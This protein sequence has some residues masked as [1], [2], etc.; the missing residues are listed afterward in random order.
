[1]LARLLP[2]ALV[3]F[4][5]AATFA[6]DPAANTLTLEEKSA[7]WKLLF[8][9]TSTK[10]WHSIGK[11]TPPPAAWAAEEGELRLLKKDGKTGGGDIVTEEEFT[12]F[13]L[14]WDWNI[15]EGGNS[16][17]KYNLPDPTKGVGCEYQLLDDEKNEDA[18]VRNGT[19]VTAS[20]YDLIPPAADKK[21]NPAGQ[22]NHSRLLVHGNHVEQWI[23]GGK[24]VS[25]DFG[26]PEMTKLIEESKFKNTKGWGVKTKSPILL[27]DHGGAISFKN[28][29]IRHLAAK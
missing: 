26:S 21:I 27:Q 10:G 22:W 14:T 15:A 8:D 5:A 19:H 20:L 2:L 7:G 12:D 13:E 17:L 23:N 28:I 25:F 29:K 6:A 18:K 3:A 9:G 1:M 24:V 4:S 11:T 16:G